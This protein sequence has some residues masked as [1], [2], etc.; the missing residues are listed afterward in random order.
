MDL[1]R[2]HIIQ[3]ADKSVRLPQ[4]IDD[5]K[6]AWVPG[7]SGIDR[8]RLIAERVCTIMRLDNKMQNMDFVPELATWLYL[9][10]GEF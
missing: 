1:L 3:H 9:H 4:L 2:S 10:N 6:E 5:L 8:F 7:L